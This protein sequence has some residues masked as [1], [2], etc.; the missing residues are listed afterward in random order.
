MKQEHASRI[1]TI[2]QRPELEALLMDERT[3]LFAC[4]EFEKGL[5]DEQWDKYTSELLFHHPMHYE[6]SGLR[7]A[8]SASA[9]Q[10]CAAFLA[11]MEG[12]GLSGEGRV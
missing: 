5:T 7:V 2:S 6:W 9:A 4:A 12:K 3:A 1:A 10:R 11:V 8:A